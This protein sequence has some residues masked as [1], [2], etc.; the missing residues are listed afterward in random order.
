[1]K[2]SL[3]FQKALKA[4]AP[5]MAGYLVLALGFGLL[6]RTQGYGPLWALAMSTVI[7]AGSM[8]FLAIDLITGGAGLLTA[9]LTTLLV[10]ARHLFYGLSMVEEYRD[11]GRAKPYLIYAL[12]DETYSIVCH[13][14]RE[15]ADEDRTRYYF[16]V[17][18][19]DQASWVLGSVLGGVLG[20][21]LRFNSEGLDFALTALFV[22]VVTDQWLTEKDHG[23]ALVGLLA[24]LLCRRLFGADS[25]LLPSMLLIL[26]GLLLLRRRKGASA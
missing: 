24:T 6:L 2:K 25:F 10:N 9:A 5:V 15:L 26:L 19:L 16:Y 3:V 23:A 7:Y 17:T 22:T 18:L 1:M 11:A 12:S 4:A 13:P 20:G 21:L 14:P 8:Q